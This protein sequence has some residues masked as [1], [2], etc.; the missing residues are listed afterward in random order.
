MHNCKSL[1]PIT[2]T[3]LIEL[4]Q[5]NMQFYAIL[6]KDHALFLKDTL[7]PTISLGIS[8]AGPKS[9]SF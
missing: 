6:T 9:F 7:H 3:K 2:E 5:M 1:L 4:N 8:E